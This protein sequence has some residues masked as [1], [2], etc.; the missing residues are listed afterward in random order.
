MSDFFLDE[1][2]DASE[3]PVHLPTAEEETGGIP[4]T[5]EDDFEGDIDDGSFE[6]VSD[7]LDYDPKDWGEEPA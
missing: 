5:E 4:E 6:D 7:A 3:A 1:E 2:Q